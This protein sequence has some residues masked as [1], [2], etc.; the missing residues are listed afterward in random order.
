MANAL[1]IGKSFHFIFFL[2]E[3]LLY[4]PLLPHVMS[5]SVSKSAQV[6]I[7]DIFTF[8]RNKLH[9]KVLTYCE[10]SRMNCGCRNDADFE[11]S[12][13]L[14]SLILTIGIENWFN[15]TSAVQKFWQKTETFK[16][17]FSPMHQTS[18]SVFSISWE[19]T[20]HL[21]ENGIARQ[22]S[23]VYGRLR[24]DE[25]PSP[26][27]VLRMQPATNVGVA[28]VL[29]LW[30]LFFNVSLCFYKEGGKQDLS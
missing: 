15:Q 21:E 17:T 19:K 9:L 18:W 13:S 24:K 22:Q 8:L 3:S 1:Y 23:R 27:V 11:E 16:H 2:A 25:L 4:V 7:F 6:V 26:T 30:S 14:A 28:S 5:Q 10:C 29:H 20:E 12:F